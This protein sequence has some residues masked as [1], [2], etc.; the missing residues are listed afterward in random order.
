[1]SLVLFLAFEN[2]K[3][4]MTE[5][6]ENQNFTFDV[7][8]KYWNFLSFFL[9][10]FL[11]PSIY[12]FLT[13]FLSFHLFC[14]KCYIGSKLFPS[15]NIQIFPF[16]FLP[17]SSIYH[18]LYLY[19]SISYKHSFR[20]SIYVTSNVTSVPNCSPATTCQL[21]PYLPSNSI[22]KKKDL[23]TTSHYWN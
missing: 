8:S 23:I 20:P 13:L 12:L 19:L 21:Q 2:P 9:P 16:S 6:Q 18:S 11:S 15:Q 17:I 14:L 7:L 5:Q 4:V 10:L 22:F 1:M 3:G